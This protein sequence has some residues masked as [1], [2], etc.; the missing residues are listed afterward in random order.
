MPD[1]P[2]LFEN[3]SDNE[4]INFVSDIYGI[5]SETRKERFDYYLGFFDLRDAMDNQIA[6]YFHGMA[7]R[8]ALIGALINDSPVIFLDDPMVGLDAKSAYNLKQI[9]RERA[10]AGKIVFF[11]ISKYSRLIAFNNRNKYNL[12]KSQGA[13]VRRNEIFHLLYNKLCSNNSPSNPYRSLDECKWWQGPCRNRCP[14]PTSNSPNSDILR[15][16]L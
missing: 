6:S 10:A 4:Y 9:L 14:F 12:A 16:S 5:D 15:A 13:N 1:N 2:D 7:Q 11:P 3:Y 8:L